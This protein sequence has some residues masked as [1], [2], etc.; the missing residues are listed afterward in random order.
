MAEVAFVQNMIEGGQILSKT[1]ANLIEKMVS[2]PDLK[3]LENEIARPPFH[4]LKNIFWTYL[5]TQKNKVSYL[6]LSHK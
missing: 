5:T 3:A 6:G 2:P 4:R 1:I